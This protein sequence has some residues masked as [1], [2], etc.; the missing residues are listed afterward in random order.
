MEN[1]PHT[2]VFG[3]TM[4]AILTEGAYLYMLAC[5]LISKG[6]DDQW[7]V[8]SSTFL[9]EWPALLIRPSCGQLEVLDQCT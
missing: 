1:W 6:S 2:L 7:Y 9:S 8:P 3:T 4:A 5:I